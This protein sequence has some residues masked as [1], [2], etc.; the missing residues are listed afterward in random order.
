[1]GLGG[2]DDDCRQGVIE[3]IAKNGSVEVYYEVYGSGR[4]TLLLIE[5]I[6]YS[7][8]MWYRQIEELPKAL[9]LVV[10]DNRGVGKSS[11]PPGA[12]SMNDFV[13][14]IQSVVR[15][16]GLRNLY[17]LGVSMGG[18]IAQAYYLAHGEN[19]KGLILSNTNYGKGS[20]L[21]S[22]Q[23]LKTLSEGASAAFTF[24]GIAERM[25]GAFSERFTK[26][27]RDGF[28]QLVRK[29]LAFGDDA[30]GYM[31]QLYAVAAFD[32]YKRLGEIGVP[33]LVIT[34]DKDIIV[35]PENSF[36][37]HRMIPNSRL[38]V[39]KDAGHAVCLERFRDF[40]RRVLSFIEEVES[41]RFHRVDNP[42]TL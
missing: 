40:D 42:E 33:T 12:Y 23:V 6:G 34:S 26:E 13:E 15:D 24:E 3:T 16:S 41:G 9:K 18:M 21:P 31:G 19:V 17:V 1:V 14:D 7:R 39:F 27:D 4:D 37:L 32:S 22:A 28:D 20:V 29:R 38:V 10:F 30:K 8:W 35:P 25:K 36:E 2:D 5:G 11:S